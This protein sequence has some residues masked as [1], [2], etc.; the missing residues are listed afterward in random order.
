MQDRARRLASKD[1][2]LPRSVAPSPLIFR[3]LVVVAT[4]ALLVALGL[5]GLPGIEDASAQ[6]TCVQP[7]ANLRAWWT[8]DETTGSVAADIAGLTNNGAHTNAPTPG[9]G[10]VAGALGFDGTNDFVTTPNHS[11]LLFGGG[12]LTI[13]AWIKTANS[14]GS[15]PIVDKRVQNSTGKASGYAL[16]LQNGKLAFQ[17]A[18]GT[19]SPS[20]YFN[21]FSTTTP[22]ADGRWHQVAATVKRSSPAALVLYVDGV[23]IKSFTGT[24]VLAG[25]LDETG[26]LWI[27]RR[28]PVPST[29][30]AS[31]HFKGM[32]DE[33]EIFGRALSATEVRSL[34]TAGP[35]G[36]CKPVNG[37]TN[38]T[39]VETVDVGIA[40]GDKTCP[41][42]P[43]FRYAGGKPDNFAAPADT[44]YA[45]AGLGT[46][47]SGLSAPRSHYDTVT[48]DRQF[49]E[50][51]NLEDKR[52]VCYAM[53]HVGLDD[54][55]ALASNDR[56][57]IGRASGATFS[58][59]AAQ[60][61]HP[62]APGPGPVAPTWAFNAAGIT[63]LSTITG[64]SSPNNAVLDI[65]LQDD[66]TIDH[67]MLWVWYHP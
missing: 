7:P 61:V 37:L 62:G 22:I 26:P 15:Q 12:S 24:S 14:S 55:N 27:G 51:F 32:I 67:M 47:M 66:T 46:F 17:L 41:N 4:A 45:G 13:D 33:V 16:F 11:E 2:A 60:V 65:F 18:N 23:P 8:F 9:V 63:A 31:A 36:K 58:P 39:P 64:S 59:L 43:Y 56:L 6:T 42:Q 1:R 40:T 50:S 35:S 19:R 44:S 20:G 54:N 5:T 34:Y 3:K 30:Y 57:N 52:R 10:Q 25:S 21:Y 29:S 48:P 49:G 28:R 38:L 53:L